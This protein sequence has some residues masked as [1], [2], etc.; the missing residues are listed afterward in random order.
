[1]EQPIV[2]Y[3][4]ALA[5]AG[6]SFYT[7]DKYPGGR[8]ARCSW[9]L[10]KG[11]QLRRLE[12]SGDKVTHQEVVFAEFGRVRDIV[13]GPDGYFYIEL[14]NPT[15]VNGISLAASTPGMLIRLMPAK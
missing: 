14:Q 7:G 4:P 13:Q 3:T 11:Q 2:Y 10:S 12:V 15:G 8:T 9:E 1:M 5:P 6:I